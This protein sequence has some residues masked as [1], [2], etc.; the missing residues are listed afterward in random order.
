LPLS[1]TFNTVSK[2][3]PHFTLHQINFSIYFYDRETGKAFFISRWCWVLQ[4]I[5]KVI[6][7]RKKKDNKPKITENKTELVLLRLQL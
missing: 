4:T 3:K 1:T 6:V 5:F 2:K 7:D